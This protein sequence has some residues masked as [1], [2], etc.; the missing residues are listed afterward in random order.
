MQATIKTASAIYGLA[1][2]SLV[3][4]WAVFI[5]SAVNYYFLNLAN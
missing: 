4:I 5:T 1:L 2:G 3:L